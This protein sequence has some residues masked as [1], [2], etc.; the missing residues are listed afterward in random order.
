MVTGL[1][2]LSGK[3]LAMGSICRTAVVM[4]IVI[5]LAALVLVFVFTAVSEGPDQCD[6][7]SRHGG[8]TVRR[9][10]PDC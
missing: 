10:L 1:P 3:A 5:G 4:L 2:G 8:F 9:V 6:E 7:A